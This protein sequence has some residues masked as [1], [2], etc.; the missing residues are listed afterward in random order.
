MF[1]VMATG[2]ILSS[3]VT[4]AEAEFVFPLWSVTVRLTVFAP[5]SEQVKSVTSKLKLDTEQLSVEPL[6]ICP[7][8][9]EAF[10]K[11]SNCIVVF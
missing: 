10:P 7:S 8:V 11:A 9:I 6:S 3:T 5:K 4:V 2:S 1:C